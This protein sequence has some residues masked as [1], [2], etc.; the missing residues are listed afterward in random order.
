MEKHK[1]K[2]QMNYHE[3]LSALS[4]LLMLIYVYDDLKMQNDD[5]LAGS[6]GLFFSLLYCSTV[7]H[8]RS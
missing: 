4:L 3:N 5:S 1:Q 7:L 6:A 2:K 8:T